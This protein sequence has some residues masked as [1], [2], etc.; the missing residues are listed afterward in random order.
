MNENLKN[1][2]KILK[3]SGVGVM[4]TD[5]IYGLV[6]RAEDKKAV[7]RIYK[8][9]RRNKKKPFII[10]I[11]NIQDLKKF[12]VRHPYKLQFVRMSLVT[13]FSFL[14]DDLSQKPA[15]TAIRTSR[16]IASLAKNFPRPDIIDQGLNLLFDPL[17]IG[18]LNLRA[19][20]RT[21]ALVIRF[22][23]NQGRSDFF[24]LINRIINQQ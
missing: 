14:A 9:K 10:L 21:T 17:Q 15:Q 20:N 1:I 19:D 22:D 11:S 3:S 2:I 12:G 23:K 18:C 13:Q 24:I 4:P 16:V 8:I 7:E 6:G 5:T